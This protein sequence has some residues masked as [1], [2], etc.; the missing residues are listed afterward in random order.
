MTDDRAA[1]IFT[2]MLK[3]SV[4]RASRALDETR[5]EAKRSTRRIAAMEETQKDAR[6]KR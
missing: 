2:E 4:D 1:E 5:R 3:R 6:R